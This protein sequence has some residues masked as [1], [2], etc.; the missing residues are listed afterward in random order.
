MNEVNLTILT[1]TAGE[2]IGKKGQQI[3][4]GKRKTRFRVQDSDSRFFVSAS[5]NRLINKIILLFDKHG[6][7]IELKLQDRRAILLNINSL[8][9]RLHVSRKKILKAAAEGKL[10]DLILARTNRAQ[11]IVEKSELV[12]K[13][14]DP[15]SIDLAKNIKLIT[16]LFKNAAAVF[17][18]L[19]PE[20]IAS[21][22]PQNTT[23]FL[24]EYE[25]TEYGIE[26]VTE[27]AKRSKETVEESPTSSVQTKELEVDLELGKGGFGKVYRTTTGKAI[28]CAHK[29]F[30]N[31]ANPNKITLQEQARKDLEN[32]V[33]LSR[34]IN[35]NGPVWGVETALGEVVEW[36]I[37]KTQAELPKKS[38]EDQS[39]IRIYGYEDPIPTPLPKTKSGSIRNVYDM[40]GESYANKVKNSPFNEKLPVLHQILS[41][42]TY[43]LKENIAHRDIKLSNILI[44][45]TD[46][47]NHIASLSDLGGARKIPNIDNLSPTELRNLDLDHL[48]D[49]ARTT[50]YCLD[51][52]LRDFKTQ[53]EECKKLQK[54][55][56]KEV[57]LKEALQ[58]LIALDKKMDIF[59]AGMA[60]YYLLAPLNE[61][62]M[63]ELP[64]KF[65]VG[66]R[67]NTDY[68]E[69]PTKQVPQEVKD[70]VR[71][72]L[73][74]DPVRR[75]DNAL[76]QLEDF[77]KA[78]DPKQFNKILQAKLQ[79]IANQNF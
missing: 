20:L 14:L 58:K 34:E 73:D 48:F 63:L 27:H 47:G 44:K 15:Q 17:D 64:Y 12:S 36:T 38:E 33:T 13:E 62:A 74:P 25:Y 5:D 19:E 68:Q 66:G 78:S 32:E 51:C 54:E 77:M 46:N 76:E 53:L 6:K 56:G 40:T 2:A 4:A 26:I 69:I 30:K 52:D 75:P 37:T 29:K 35:K 45:E 8:S 59:A 21:K 22:I 72:M 10:E 67:K 55:E 60:I 7:N 31:A 61:A 79:F 16:L 71:A 1:S 57:E 3:A 65:N 39:P 50:H 49:T 28:K 70:L 41:G 18:Q 43:F 11:K 42:L 9:D 24:E 23:A